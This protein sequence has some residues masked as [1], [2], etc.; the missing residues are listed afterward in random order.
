MTLANTPTRDPQGARHRLTVHSEMRGPCGEPPVQQD[1]LVLQEPDHPLRPGAARHARRL[2]IAE[3]A[4]KHG[5]VLSRA[6]LLS[7]GADRHVIR[8][9]VASGR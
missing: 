4:D 6:L 3:A 2:A 5:G 1:R 8:H 7:L 9:A